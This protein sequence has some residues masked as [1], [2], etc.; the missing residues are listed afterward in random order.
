VRDEQS[1]RSQVTS[2]GGK[3]VC[4]ISPQLIGLQAAAYL[5][6]SLDSQSKDRNY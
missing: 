6:A 1:S 3:S 4:G 5:S 2:S